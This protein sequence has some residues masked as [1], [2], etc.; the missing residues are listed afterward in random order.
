MDA[1]LLFPEAQHDL[2]WEHLN[3]HTP[4]RKAGL[5]AEEEVR[6]QELVA[7]PGRSIEERARTLIALRW[8][9]REW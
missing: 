3:G 6:A 2:V 1:N 5:P 8:G 4:E 9:K 7:N